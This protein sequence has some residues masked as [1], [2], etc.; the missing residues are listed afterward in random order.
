[1]AEPW[2]GAVPQGTPPSRSAGASKPATGPNAPGRGSDN[3]RAA[4][5]RQ[6]AGRA[7]QLR[8][9]T[10]AADHFLTS[11]LGDDRKTG[12]WLISTALSLADTLAE[13]LDLMVRGLKESGS[14]ASLVGALEKMRIQTHQVHASVRGAEHFIVVESGED[15]ETGGWLIATALNLAQGL[16]SELD[17]LA[18]SLKRSANDGVIDVLPSGGGRRATA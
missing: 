15:R 1:M 17:D 13:D 6:L 18:S 12:S 2:M 11:G 9:S 8:A 10:R 7:Y 3:E 16:A 4:T 5:L 14:E